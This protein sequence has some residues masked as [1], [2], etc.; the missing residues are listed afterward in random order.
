[1]QV[2]ISDCITVKLNGSKGQVQSEFCKG[3]KVV[4]A[5]GVPVCKR[6]WMNSTCAEE[7]KSPMFGCAERMCAPTI[8][9]EQIILVFDMFKYIYIYE[10]LYFGQNKYF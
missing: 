7:I 3:Q 5:A 9:L 6:H 10:L 1:M 2:C 8:L 4:S